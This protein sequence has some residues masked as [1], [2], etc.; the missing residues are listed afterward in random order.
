MRAAVLHELHRSMTIEDVAVRKPRRD[1]VLIRTA[2]TGICHS[3]LLVAEGVLP[4]P[5]PTVLGHESSGFVEAVGEDVRY[6]KPGDRVI[7]CTSVFCGA[8]DQCL[9]GHPALCSDPDVKPPP[10]QVDRLAWRG[11]RLHQFV[12]LS[13]FAEQMLV[14]QSGVV[15]VREEMPLDRA[16]LLGCAVTTG[17]GAVFTTARIEPGSTVAVFGCGGIGLSCINGAALAG[18]ARVIAVDL[19]PAKLALARRMGA[20]DT[21]EASG[22]D[23]VG[24]ILEATRGGV[25][26]AFECV[27]AKAAAEQA[28]A[29]LRP[30]GAAVMI[31]VLP[32]GTTLQINWQ[33][34]RRDR[35]ILGS[36]MG[37]N[38]FRLDMP[39][40]V[41]FYLQGR[42]HLDALISGHIGLDRINEGFDDLRAG[43]VVRNLVA[44]PQ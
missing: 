41:E 18:A 38:R 43:A 9:V 15:K 16:A 39:R 8:C 42:L 17:V 34:L 1:E 20:T 13:G 36:Y 23:V 33:A 28:I 24:E 19:V 22:R 30:A 7:T 26:Y 12:H 31:G 2:F 44:F 37:S 25:H 6:V 40:L 3:D 27:G 35:K 5:T 14:H 4:Q 29:V 11:Q 32:E 10:T 21:V